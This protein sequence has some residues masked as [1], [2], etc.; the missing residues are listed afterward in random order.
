MN[1]AGCCE[2]ALLAASWRWLLRAGAGCYELVLVAT[3]WCSERVF[4]EPRPAPAEF[5]KFQSDSTLAGPFR[6]AV[7]IARSRGM[8]AVRI[9]TMRL[10]TANRAGGRVSRHLWYQPRDPRAGPSA[11]VAVCAL[12]AA[13]ATIALIE[14]RADPTHRARQPV[15]VR[16]R[17]TVSGDQTHVLQHNGAHVERNAIRRR[18]PDCVGRARGTVCNHAS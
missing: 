15:G 14:A 17:R 11:F 12:A 2:L 10:N 8:T 6:Q 9:L 13:P 7:P 16:A 5:S 18:S 3:S 1:S 4:C